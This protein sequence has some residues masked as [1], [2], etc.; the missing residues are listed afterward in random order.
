MVNKGQ[1]ATDEIC[2]DS[3][4]EFY[5]YLQEVDRVENDNLMRYYNSLQ[6]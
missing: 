3:K 2:I 1:V 4:K 6:L 5:T